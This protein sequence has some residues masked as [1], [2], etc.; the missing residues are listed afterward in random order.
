MIDRID[1]K[2]KK[3]LYL[4]ILFLTSICI[5]GIFLY[6]ERKILGISSTYHPDAANY[7]NASTFKTYKY[8][9]TE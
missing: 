3:F 1:F 4:S 5:S 6:L 9:S 8:L 2:I 7:I